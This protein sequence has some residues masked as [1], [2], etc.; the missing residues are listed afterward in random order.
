VGSTLT[1][2]TGGWQPKGLVFT[3]QWL[4]NGTTIAHATASSYLLTSADL[5]ASISV[6]VTGSIPNFESQ[7]KTVTAT[8]EPTAPIRPA[9]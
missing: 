6:S 9:E 5:G 7:G 4:R 1:A 3:Y 2:H 8:S